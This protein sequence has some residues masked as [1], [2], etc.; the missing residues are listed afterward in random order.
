[1][2]RLFLSSFFSQVAELFVEFMENGQSGKRVTFIPTA[3]NPEKVTFFVDA[4]RKALEKLGMTVDVLDI[5]AADHETMA[6]KIAQSDCIFVA[7]GNT[8]YLLQ[9]LRRTGADALISN[10]ILNGKPYIGSS[11]GSVILS[12]NIAYVTRMDSP[13]EAPLLS[14]FDSLGAIDFYPLPHHTNAPFKKTV[15]KIIAAYAGKIDLRP[16]RNDQVFT[17]AGDEA[18][19]RTR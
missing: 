13:V 7:G 5:A 18:V 14:N 9:E 16:F 10:E 2:K 6:E 3:A 4:D 17:V 11:A 12:K 19:L 15:E 1:M 8:F